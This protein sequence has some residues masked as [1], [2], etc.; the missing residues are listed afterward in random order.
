MSL[1]AKYVDIDA[2]LLNTNACEIYIDLYLSTYQ[3]SKDMVEFAYSHSQK[4]AMSI[5][6]QFKNNLT[7]Q[8]IRDYLYHFNIVT[9][10]LLCSSKYPFSQFKDVF[11]MILLLDKSIK[12]QNM[13]FSIQVLDFTKSDV[14][15]HKFFILRDI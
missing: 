13:P 2:D 10:T 7:E 12:A 9:E 11:K 15:N 1:E 3:T 5:N 4:I 6:S 14:G 8:L